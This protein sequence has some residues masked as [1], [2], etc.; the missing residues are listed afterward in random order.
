V[1]VC[2]AFEVNAPSPTNTTDFTISMPYGASF[3]VGVRGNQIVFDCYWQTQ[4]ITY[5]NRNF[6]YKPISTTAPVTWDDVT[7]RTNFIA[8]LVINQGT[9]ALVE[10]Y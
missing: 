5:V 10:K 1:T 9:Y 6:S 7:D 8:F 2:N 4:A 3:V